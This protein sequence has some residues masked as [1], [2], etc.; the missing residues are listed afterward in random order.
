MWLV[1]AAFLSRQGE[2]EGVKYDR[3]AVVLISTGWCRVSKDFGP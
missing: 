3:I 1:K 2:V